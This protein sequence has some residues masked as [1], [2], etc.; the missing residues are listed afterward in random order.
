MP[1]SPKMSVSTVYGPVS[2][3]YLINNRWP[4]IEERNMKVKRMMESSS[5]RLIHGAL[6]ATFLVCAG[7]AL[8]QP[9]PGNS[10]PPGGG[11]GP[12]V[13]PLPANAPEPS[14]DPRNFDGTWYHEK[15]LEFQIKTDLYGYKTPFNAAGKKVMDRR[16]DS[17]KRGTP[18]IN[19]STK[20]VPM[21]QPWQ[22]DLNMPFQIFQT[23]DRFD[24]LFEEYHG[25]LQIVM[26]PAK[27]PPAGYM[28]RSVARWDGDTL[29]VE[30]SGYKD[31]FWL[32]VNGTPASKNAKL[33]QRIRKLKTDHWFLDIVYTLDDPTYYTRPWSW[34]R[35]YSWRPDMAIFRE[36]N[37][38]EQIGTKYGIDP[39]LVPEPND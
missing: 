28:G 14:P 12:M 8:A 21:G 1:L 23:N 37:C 35:D 4:Q 29:V 9:A 26:D 30:T 16:L 33:T 27:A 38:E 22:M 17:L 31:G 32:D 18:F 24:V 5:R 11:F 39:S 25:A 13:P 3:P 19:A 15:M 7:V 20:C 36:Y 10:P 2:R 6:L 34:V